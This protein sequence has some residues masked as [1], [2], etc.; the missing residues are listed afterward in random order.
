MPNK[1]I[2]LCAILIAIGCTEKPAEVVAPKPPDSIVS[3]FADLPSPIQQTL[4]SVTRGQRFSDPGKKWNATDV[5]L[6]PSIP[7]RRLVFAGTIAG[8]WFAYY[9]HGGRGK[10]EH[11]VVFSEDGTGK[12]SVAANVSPHRPLTTV[13]DVKRLLATAQYR[14]DDF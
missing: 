14:M 7:Q 4:L 2:S 10:H 13:A 5:I 8:N 3:H 1:H 11:V 12:A 6:D 9:E